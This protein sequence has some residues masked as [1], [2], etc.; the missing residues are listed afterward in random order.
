MGCGQHSHSLVFLE[1]LQDEEE[2][3]W[4]VDVFGVGRLAWNFFFVRQRFRPT[5]SSHHMSGFF[6]NGLVRPGLIHG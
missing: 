1:L 5:L 3:G 4:H 6:I 2:D